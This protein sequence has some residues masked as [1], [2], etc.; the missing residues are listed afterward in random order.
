MMKNKILQLTI[1]ISFLISTTN[2]IARRR[3]RRRKIKP[4][5]KAWLVTS[6]NGKKVFTQKNSKKIRSIASLTKMMATIVI[7]EHGI[8]L[9]KKTKMIK[10]DW[11][12]G[13]GG[14]RTRLRKNHI[15][16]NRDLLHA[17]LLGSDNRAI[18]ALGR[19]VG[20][21][22]NALVL[23]MNKKA[24]R[25]GL[26]HT[27]FKDPTGID[28][29]NVSTAWEI[30]KIIRV[31]LKNKIVSTIMKK[32]TY[33]I[34]EK[35][36]NRRIRYN[37]TNI[38]T[39]YKA[40][41]VLAGKT[42]FNSSAGYCLVTANKTRKNGIVVYIILGSTGM[43]TRFADYSILKRTVK[44]I[45]KKNIKKG[46]KYLA[47]KKRKYRKIKKSK[48]KRTVSKHKRNKKIK[49]KKKKR[50]R[51]NSRRKNKRFRFNKTKKRVIAKKKR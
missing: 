8:R 51:A 19:A 10:Y 40:S 22:A 16:T 6:L 5:A 26:K 21:N 31:A 38:L 24:K 9:N 42:G 49:Y 47:R 35:K 30:L 2:T 7:V 50:T 41:G 48:N 11:K 46:S 45:K 18:P 20:L 43:Y 3:R 33:T 13:G 32:T 29:G 25:M 39:R 4:R 37:N 36:F 23:A 1:I 44:S 27:Y 34:V 28:H 14:A 15:Y 12:I 17:A